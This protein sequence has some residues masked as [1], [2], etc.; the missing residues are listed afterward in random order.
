VTE[1]CRQEATIAVL[2]DRS[3][4][5]ESTLTQIASAIEENNRLLA[6]LTEQ[7]AEIRHLRDTQ[8]RLENRYERDLRNL[9]GRVRDLELA[10]G[11]TL[12]K[13]A[14]IL[15]T[16]ASSCIGGIVAGLVIWSVKNA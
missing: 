5:M 4:K 12:G 15:I 9:F 13:L 11:K 6:V 10:P 3:K 1:P 14:I 2:A 7:G 8:Q 16:A